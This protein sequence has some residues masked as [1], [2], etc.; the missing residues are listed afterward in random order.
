M[1]HWRSRESPGGACCWGSSISLHVEFLSSVLCHL[2]DIAPPRFLVLLYQ[3]ESG[4]SVWCFYLHSSCTLVQ[5]CL[6]FVAD[7]LSNI[8]RCWVV[9]YRHNI[10]QATNHLRRPKH[11]S[12]EKFA[13]PTGKNDTVIS[14][15]RLA[16][17]LHHVI[18][19]EMIL[20]LPTTVVAVE[21]NVP[22][23]KTVNW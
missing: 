22:F 8:R 17:T 9:Y 11:Q 10:I 21:M 5:S 4:A 2:N 14:S 7:Q 12:G 3:S 13:W 18:Y 6:H 20:V 23:S 1:I 15:C 16:K 19:K